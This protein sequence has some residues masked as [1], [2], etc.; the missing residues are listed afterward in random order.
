MKYRAGID[1][2]KKRLDKYKLANP[3]WKITIANESVTF[4]LRVLKQKKH[5]VETC[6]NLLYNLDNYI[7]NLAKRIQM[8][9]EDNESPE[10][11]D[12]L[13]I[14]MGDLLRTRKSFTDSSNSWQ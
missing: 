7:L 9:E 10:V 4:D 6:S 13:Y 8:C 1:A 14:L 2:R 3:V 12:D 5:K 11:I